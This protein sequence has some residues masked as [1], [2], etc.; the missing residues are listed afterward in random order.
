MAADDPVANK[1]LAMV[2]V[3]DDDEDVRWALK[4]Q[5]TSAGIAAETHPSGLAFLESL[6]TLGKD[7]VGC[8]LTDVRMPGLTGLELLGRLLTTGFQRPVV[9]MTGHGDISMA[10]KAM[11]AG[12]FD[13]IEKPF[14]DDELLAIIRS[15]LEAPGII[16]TRAPPGN[17][18]VAHPRAVEAAA[19]IAALSSRE[20]DVLAKAMEG[21]ANKVI[22]Y[23]LGLS[24]RTVEIYRARLMESLGVRSLAEAVRLAARAELV[25]DHGDP[26]ASAC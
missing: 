4:L 13:F 24:P 18:Y 20:R 12:A 26:S 11:K 6:P 5:L 7:A 3:I 19:R 25:E 17:G 2:H 8:V 10:V 23:E 1:T 9:V 21:K 22:A 16:P 15:A 14:D